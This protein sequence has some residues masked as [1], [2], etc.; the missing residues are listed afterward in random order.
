MS[1]RINSDVIKAWAEGEPIQIWSEQFGRWVD[2]D[3]NYFSNAKFRIKPAPKILKTKRYVYGD[4]DNITI[5]LHVQNQ[6]VSSDFI[7]WL[8]DD[9]VEFEV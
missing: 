5:G 3:P 8:D 9:W 1:P 2:T 6:W 4:G 7:C